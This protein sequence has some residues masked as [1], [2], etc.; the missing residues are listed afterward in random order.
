MLSTVGDSL[1]GTVWTIALR[2]RA[3]GRLRIDTASI[4]ADMAAADID[5]V[6]D[7]ESVLEQ[8]EEAGD[9]VL[10]QRLRAK[11]DGDAGD[12]GAGQQRRDVEADLRTEPSDAAIVTRIDQHGACAAAATACARASGRRGRCRP[13]GRSIVELKNSHSTSPATSDQHERDRCSRGGLLGERDQPG[14]GADAPGLQQRQRRER[15]DR[16]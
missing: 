16:R 10:D 9:D 14:E 5:A 8:D 2:C 3:G 13:D 7:R 12:A 15:I 11:A 1:N 4:D 6:A